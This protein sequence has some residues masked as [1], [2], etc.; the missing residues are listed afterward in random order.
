MSD[1][2][3]WAPRAARALASAR[4]MPELPPVMK[5]ELSDQVP[6]GTPL[7]RWRRERF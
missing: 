2:Q 6:F 3:T 4:P 7:S 1:T 5:A